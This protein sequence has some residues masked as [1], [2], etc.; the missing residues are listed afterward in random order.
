MPTSF[1]FHPA[2]KWPLPYGG[3]KQDHQLLFDE[4]EWCPTR[5]L[6]NGLVEKTLYASPVLNQKIVLDD[7]LFDRGAIV[8]DRIKS[9]RITYGVRGLTNI[10]LEFPDMPHFGL[11][12]KPGADFICLEPWQGFAAPADFE[13]ELKAKPGM[14]SIL[15]GAFADFI[16][17]INL[18]Y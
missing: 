12:T 2:F 18:K 13:G 17:S 16:M 15:P 8:F 5:R 6:V 9:H 7:A 3:R 1:G 14:I 10:C 4:V 11:W